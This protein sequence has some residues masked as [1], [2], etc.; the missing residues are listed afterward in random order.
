[1]ECG[2]EAVSMKS[3]AFMILGNARHRMR[4]FEMKCF[5][6]FDF[7]FTVPNLSK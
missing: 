5:L 4:S 7:L 1:M 6:E 3:T 2:L